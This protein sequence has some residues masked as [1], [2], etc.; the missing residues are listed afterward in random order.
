ML[1]TVD[2]RSVYLGVD[3]ILV[4]VT[5]H[6]FPS[7]GSYLKFAVSFLSGALS[8]ARTGLQFAVQ[9]LNGPSRAEPV[10]ILYRLI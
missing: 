8:D 9:S 7:E 6:Y 3:P 1:Y 10:T 5:R 4:L 2:G